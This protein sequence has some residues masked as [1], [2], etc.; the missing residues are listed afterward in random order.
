MLHF[1]NYKNDGHSSF[2]SF[3]WSSINVEKKIEEGTCRV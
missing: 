3:S 2:I 1:Y